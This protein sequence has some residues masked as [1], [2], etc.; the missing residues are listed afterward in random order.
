VGAVADPLADTYGVSLAVVGLLTTALFVGHL[1]AQL[2]AGL[3]A[4][5]LGARAVALATIGLALVGNGIALVAPHLA[6]GIAGRAIV[7]LGS[8][9]GFVAGLDLVR[10]GGGGP[11][12]QGL[13]GGA[14]MAGGG[15]ALMTLPVLTDA[16]G[17]RAPYWS[18]IVLALAAAPLTFAARDLPRAGY[19]RG[20]I[21]RDARLLPLGA[22]Q[23]ATFG[24][25]V[26]AGN[27]VVTLLER[28]GAGSAVAGLAGS[29]T[30]FAGILTRPGGGLLARRHVGRARTLVA[31]SLTSAAA[32]AFLLAAALSLPL[33]AL[34]ALILGL[35]AGVPFATI[36]AA[37]VALR[38]DAPAA[39]I[40]LV[41]GCAV[42]TILVGVPLA[43][44][45]FALP[46]EGRIGFLAIG[47]LLLASL[48]AV[49]RSRL[50]LA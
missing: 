20:A 17:W 32:G 8:G 26:I 3:G 46:G 5:R 48:L 25:V 24:L 11:V 35:A 1:V 40:G 47:V 7:G 18:A 23:A 28:E 43:G 22:L 4:D 34:A 19:S 14:T 30:L 15:L 13:Y 33:S 38:P 36:F 31:V 27:W 39:A 10:A 50:Q 49:R 42:L 41:N 45:T 21:V 12:A 44:L 16:T 37:T 6:L 29:M 2:P 9:G